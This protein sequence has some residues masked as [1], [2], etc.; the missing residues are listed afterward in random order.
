MKTAAGFARP[1][2]FWLGALALFTCSG[3]PPAAEGGSA[4]SPANEASRLEGLGERYRASGDAA[5]LAAVEKK[6]TGLKIDRRDASLA[7]G[8]LLRAEGR[9]AEAA[10]VLEQALKQSPKD[11]EF[12]MEL[13]KCYLRMGRSDRAKAAFAQAKRIKGRE[14][15]AY[16]EQGYAYMYAGETASAQQAFERLIALEPANP[17]GYQHLGTYFIRHKQYRKAEEHFRQAVRLLEASPR[18]DPDSLGHALSWLAD[19]LRAQ[20]RP[21][22]AEAVYRKAVERSPITTFW[23][24]Y[25]W[26]ALGELAAK[27]GKPAEAERAIQQALRTAAA[28]ESGVGCSRLEWADIVCEVGSYYAAQGRKPE[29]AALAER[30]GNAYKTVPS[31]EHSIRQMGELAN[32]YI[33]LGDG[34]KAEALL[35]RVLAARGALPADPFIVQA[36]AA[37]AGLVLERGRWAEAEEL[38]LKVIDAF[39]TYGDRSSA[40]DALDGLATALGKE[41]KVPQAAAALQ[42]ALALA[43]EPYH[44][45]RLGKRFRAAGDAAGLAAVENKL[46]GLKIDRP[47]ALLAL[48]CLLQS[49]KKY[50]EAAV[51]LEHS[52]TLQP[53]DFWAQSQL[54]R[55][56]RALGQYEQAARLM[57]AALRQR[58][59]D[60]VLAGELGDCYLRMGIHFDELRRPREAEANFRRA[61]RRLEAKPGYNPR[62]LREALQR[63]GN[64]LRN[65]GQSTKAERY[66]RQALATCEPGPGCP[67]QEWAGAATALGDLYVAQD[68]KPEAA[69]LA[70]WLEQVYSG[71]AVDAESIA[72][73]SW[74]A[75]LYLKLG[76]RP[77]AEAVLRRMLAARGALPVDPVMIDAEA[78]LAGL[79]KAQGRRGELEELYLREVEV[80]KGHG[81]K[82]L[83]AGTLARLAAV[84]DEEGKGAA[85]AAARR[86]AEA[87]RA[88]GGKS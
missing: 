31:D 19:A 43:D 51:A 65:Q 69:A 57:E 4:P 18:P 76:D 16:L 66:Y 72:G 82:G 40:G 75:H 62:E 70:G 55:A 20:Q 77:R 14:F 74:L 37:L 10:D 9:D 38:Y 44:L 60:D 41:G 46:A 8:R 67:R 83:A 13:G 25:H 12:A 28:C 6:L 27:Q 2:L 79:Y 59:A 36:E 22:E 23:R 1:A 68:R 64:S 33:K 30:V 3:F 32:L 42:Q 17:L 80:F 78:A 5:G 84:Y 47:A 63:L 11:Y 54:G 29:A 71:V 87:L 34:A 56:Y 15:Q 49:E 21:A 53:D 7:L 45:E 24:A 61:L 86:Q 58:P 50:A 88:Q 26:R 52:L 85:A 39:K 81:D 73:V 48:G 35:R